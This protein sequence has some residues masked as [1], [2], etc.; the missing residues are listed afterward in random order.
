MIK[1][2]IFDLDGTLVNSIEDLADS[3][4]YALTKNGFPTHEGY[5]YKHFVGDGVQMLIKRALPE[6]SRSDETILKVK[7]DF[8]EYYNEHYSSKTK[9]YNGINELLSELKA[10]EISM[11]VASNKPDEFSKVIVSLFFGDTFTFVQGNTT[12]IPKKPDPQIVF[13]ILEK[14]NIKK[15]ECLFVGDSDIDIMTAKAAGIKSIGCLWGFRDLEELTTAKADHIVSE[16][17]EILK[18]I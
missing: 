8:S 18:Y 10:K 4:N 2:I 14:L 15:S 17:I 5:K 3:S 12:Q 1:L 16:P 6:N 9:P 11:A 7:A 13:F